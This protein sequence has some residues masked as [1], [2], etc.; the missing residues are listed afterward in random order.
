MMTTTK[1]L[2]KSNVNNKKTNNK[3]PNTIAL[4]INGYKAMQKVHPHHIY[5]PYNLLLLQYRLN[6]KTI[7]KK[8]RALFI[9]VV[10][11]IM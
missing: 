8:Y 9:T 6:I 11:G 2:Q 4:I 5:Q 10:C 7:F 1:T 3:Q